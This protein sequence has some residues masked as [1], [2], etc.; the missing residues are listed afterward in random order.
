MTGAG[1]A[2]PGVAADV[3]EAEVEAAA[4]ELDPNIFRDIPHFVSLIGLTL[5]QERDGARR[6]ARAILA[7][8]YAA[9]SAS[10]PQD[11]GEALRE[12]RAEV[13][14]WQARFAASERAVQLERRRTHTMAAGRQD[15][16]HAAEVAW[17]RLRR[18]LRIAREQRS[19][20]QA[21]R[22]EA[23]GHERLADL[24]FEVGHVDGAADKPWKDRA[25]A[26]ERERDEARAENEALA[27][28]LSL[29]QLANRAVMSDLRLGK[30]CTAHYPDTQNGRSLAAAHADL[31]RV[32]AVLR[33]VEWTGGAWISEGHGR[34]CPV[35]QGWDTAGHA[36][37]CALA[38]ALDP[39]PRGAKGPS[40]TRDGQGEVGDA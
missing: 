37:G 15:W 4:R 17:R 30:L 27:E 20:A 38:A 1:D 3:G 14:V 8:A 24:I 13:E 6:R 2:G 33:R 40:G 7:A 39:P 10:S 28:D 35:C 19:L 31:D 22:K 34:F 5:E 23:S 18:V 9:R 32:R 29:A 21:W 12:A 36:P 25:I 26:A 16:R 11:G